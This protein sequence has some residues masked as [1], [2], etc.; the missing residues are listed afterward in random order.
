MLVESCRYKS[1]MLF[2][3]RGFP[4]LSHALDTTVEADREN[5]NFT[6]NLERSFLP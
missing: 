3:L 4:S 2:G 6:V 1:V 5:G